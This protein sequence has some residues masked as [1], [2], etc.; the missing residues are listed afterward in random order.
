MAKTKMAM[1]MAMAF[2]IGEAQAGGGSAGGGATEVTQILNMT[3]L[4]AS[5]AQQV[6][7]YQ[8]QLQQYA[9][10]IKNL[11]ANPLGV[12]L[13][14]IAQMSS[15]AARLLNVGQDIAS[16]MSRVD[17]TFAR[18]FQRPTAE[19][20]ATKFGLWTTASQD[21]LKAAMLAAGLQRE[22]FSDDTS[23]LQSLTANL[24]SSQG[25]L[26]ALQALGSLNARQI[27]ES[28]KLR[29]LISQQQVAQNTYLSAQAAKEQ[30]RQDAQIVRFEEYHLVEKHKADFKNPKF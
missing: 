26:S 15:N 20:F 12:A 21:A 23:A 5:Y 13:P 14:Q 6:Q 10:M 4:V 27:Q 7:D 16:S 25:N 24:A 2:A 18:T 22:Q 8:N 9:T 3:Q 28:M 11:E 1:L 19:A 29:D 30:A 17:Q